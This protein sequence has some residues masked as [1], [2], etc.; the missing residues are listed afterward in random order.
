MV[1]SAASDASMLMPGTNWC[2]R[3]NRAES[4]AHLG[5][6]FRTDACCREHDLHCHAYLKKGETLDGLYNNMGYTAT[7]CECDER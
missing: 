5:A 1:R 3:G 6:A 2:G 4:Y 7:Q